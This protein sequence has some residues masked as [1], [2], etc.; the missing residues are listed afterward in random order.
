[1]EQR[2]GESKTNGFHVMKFEYFASITVNSTIAASKV[3]KPAR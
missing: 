2:L 3:W 1:M